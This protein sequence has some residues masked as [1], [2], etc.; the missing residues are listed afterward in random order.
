MARFYPKKL[1]AKLYPVPPQL[2]F[3]VL[4][5][6]RTLY[7]LN[8]L[9]NAVTFHFTPRLMDTCTLWPPP[10]NGHFPWF[11]GNRYF[12]VLL[13]H[14]QTDLYVHGIQLWGTAKLLNRKTILIFQNKLLRIMTNTPLS[15]KN[16]QLPNPS[17][18][19]KTAS[20]N[21]INTR[22]LNTYIALLDVAR[23][24]CWLN[25]KSVRL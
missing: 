9:S 1:E 10:N 8:L 6:K 19:N 2:L 14:Y 11:L 3:Y 16:N 4:F 13:H 24:N 17:R 22:I 18:K 5:I 15:T 12:E 21:F 25:R 7:E 20:P 23:G